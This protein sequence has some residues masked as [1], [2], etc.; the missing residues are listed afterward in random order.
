MT[1]DNGNTRVY[2]NSRQGV[3]PSHGHGSSN[4]DTFYKFVKTKPL[5]STV[6]T[7][8]GSIDSKEET[9]DGG[10][11][12]HY[13]LTYD[14]SLCSFR[15]SVSVFHPFVCLWRFGKSHVSESTTK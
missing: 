9:G 11:L 5:P 14:F 10:I 2:S 8:D 13:S 6:S 7:I 1:H 12:V 3:V 4:G 15:F